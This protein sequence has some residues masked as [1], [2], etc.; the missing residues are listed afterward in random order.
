MMCIYY[1]FHSGHYFRIINPNH[2]INIIIILTVHYVL[3]S[4]SATQSQNIL[5]FIH[6]LNIHCLSIHLK[7]NL[8]KRLLDDSS[9]LWYY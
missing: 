7:Q 8:K 1:I 9:R 3:C 4:T 5:L 2:N 6:L